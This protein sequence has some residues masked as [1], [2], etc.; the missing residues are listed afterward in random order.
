MAFEDIPVDIGAV[1][2]GQRIRKGD[3][4]VELGGKKAPGAE[5]VRARGADE[6]EDGRVEVIGPDIGDMEEGGTY[7]YGVYIE[8][9]GEDL[10]R[11]LESVVERRHH[12]FT[13]YIDGAM[14][15]NQRDAIWI[16]I[17][18][19]AFEKGMNSLE[20]VGRALIELFKLEM[21]YIENMQVTF[22]TDEAEAENLVERAR[23]IYEERDARARDLHEE[24]VDNF[25]GCNL[26]QSFAPDHVCA[27][28]PD[29][30]SLCGSITWFDAR[31]AARVDPDGPYFPIPKGE[32]VDE[33]HGEWTGVNEAVEERSGGVHD[34]IW[35]HTVFD[36]IHTS[37]GCFEALAFYMPEVDGVGIVDRDYSGDTP[38]GVSFSTLA[39][40]AG[41]GKQVDG[42]LGIAVEYL[43][44]PKF[45]EA[46]GG[47]ERVVWMP[48][49]IK[50]RISDAIPGELVDKIVTEET[51]IDVAELR[52]EL[53]SR[54]HPVSERWFEVTDELVERA[55][56]YI[57]STGGKVKPAE[58]AEELGIDRDQFMELVKELKKRKILA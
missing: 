27:I 15:L 30:I 31:A 42:I 56:D 6:V 13:N 32:N 25:Y 11:D 2:E 51:T 49:H 52:E 12:E 53:E 1:Y 36:N 35:L 37:C 29:R 23:E 7:P 38:Y 5:L 33:E 19:E 39:G 50:E 9:A 21:D 55:V 44:S 16:R 18:D 28:T 20:I 4:R 22:Y 14:H 3:Y 43:R 54:G 46:D 48:E 17:D 26:C 34:R 58:A 45:L 24:D 47:M 40:Q 41:G 10:D 8:M 57:R